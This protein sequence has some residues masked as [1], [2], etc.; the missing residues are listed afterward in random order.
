MGFFDKLGDSFVNGIDRAVDTEFSD[1]PRL[2]D[3]RQF[4]TR[5]SG[6]ATVPAGS[7]SQD[8]I[9]KNK[10]MLLIGAGVLLVAGAFILKRK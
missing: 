9:A 10:N 4:E 7:S 1:V 3:D 5:D 8:F 2:Q 6:T